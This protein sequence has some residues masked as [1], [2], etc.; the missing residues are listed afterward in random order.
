M[1]LETYD[2]FK[3]VVAADAVAVKQAFARGAD[4]NAA[5]ELGHNVLHYATLGSA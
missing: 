1:N 2:L 4:V 3:A 5:D